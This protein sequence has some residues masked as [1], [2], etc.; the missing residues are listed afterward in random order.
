MPRSVARTITSLTQREIDALFKRAKSV[1]KKEGLD[2]RLAPK[3]LPNAKILLVVSRKTGNSPQRNLLKRRIKSI[4]YEEQLFSQEFDWII[5]SR[6]QACA[7]SFDQI[8]TIMLY[9]Y[10]RAHD[11]QQ[12][13]NA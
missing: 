10:Q 2:I 3:S 7:L 5:V 13:T 12:P 4:F 6:S 9:A 8:K 11:Q 1:L